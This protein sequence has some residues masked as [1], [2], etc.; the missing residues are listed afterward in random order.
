MNTLLDDLMEQLCSYFPEE[1]V[2]HFSNAKK[3]FLLGV[4]ACV[5]KGI[6]ESVEWIDARAE[7][8]TKRRNTRAER[9]AQNSTHITIEEED[10]ATA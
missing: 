4:K 5:A 8:A 10:P 2:T 1:V 3:E 9:A 6:D 7:G